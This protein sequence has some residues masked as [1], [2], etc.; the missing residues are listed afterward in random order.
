MK[1][2]NAIAI[3]GGIASGKSSVCDLLKLY[4]YSIIDADK[5]A[6]NALN[7]LK[8]EVVLEFG[9]EILDS[10]NNIDRKKLGAIVF[11]DDTKRKILENILHPFIRNEIL[12]IAKELE[13]YKKVYFV[14]IPLFFEAKEKYPINRILLIYTP[15]QIQIDRLI[16]RDNIKAELAI[17]KIESQIDIESKK[18]LSTYII[19]NSKDLAHLQSQIESFIKTL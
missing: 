2:E 14:D 13:K 19:D 5:I 11:C 4:G 1:L 6:H 15:K 7:I 9:S 17:K 3:T 16:K 8:D 10:S 18:A 12:Q